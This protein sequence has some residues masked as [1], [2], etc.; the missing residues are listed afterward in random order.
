M[1]KPDVNDYRFAHLT[2]TLLLHYHVKCRSRILS[3]YNSEFTLSRLGSE[4]GS[5]EYYCET[6]KS[7]KICCYLVDYIVWTGVCSGSKSTVQRSRTSTN[8]NNA[9]TVSG[10]L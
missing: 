8:W 7:L 3:V 9:S 10:L 6:T 2:L 5:S 4:C 1:K